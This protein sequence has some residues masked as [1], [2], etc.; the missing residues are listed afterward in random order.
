MGAEEKLED[1]PEFFHTADSKGQFH[2]NGHSWAAECCPCHPAWKKFAK[3]KSQENQSVP[4]IPI[5]FHFATKIW[6][7][8]GEFP[9]PSPWLGMRNIYPNFFLLLSLYFPFFVFFLMGGHGQSR[10]YFREL[11]ET[12]VTQK[13]AEHFSPS[14]P[15]FPPLEPLACWKFWKGWEEITNI[16]QT[17]D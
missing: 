10:T 6:H 2:G 11:Q 9:S 3:G 4:D 16:W 12:A 8:P 17:S 13:D 1:L 7:P 5:C 15:H 14:L